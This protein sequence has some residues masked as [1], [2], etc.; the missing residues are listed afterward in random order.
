MII[1]VDPDTR[2]KGTRRAWELQ[3]TRMRKGEL[4]WEPHKWFKSFRSALEEAV[5]S[6]I[7]MHPV[8]GL[9]EAIEAVSGLVQHYEE[10]IPSE[11]RLAK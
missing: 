3:R 10:L 6:E 9:S 7:R 1:Q 2:I 4:T 8:N 11:Y 5:H